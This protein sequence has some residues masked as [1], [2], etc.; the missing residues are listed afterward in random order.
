M[1]ACLIIIIT[2]CL[3]DT[4]FYFANAKAA[5]GEL[6]IEGFNVSSDSPV[7]GLHML[8]FVLQDDFRYTY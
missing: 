3:L 6:A 8:I 2:V 7:S 4:Y 5:R 1:A